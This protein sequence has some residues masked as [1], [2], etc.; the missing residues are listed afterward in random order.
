[1]R[2]LSILESEE[3]STDLPVIFNF[4]FSMV[5]QFIHYLLSIEK[6]RECE[7]TVS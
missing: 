5:A 2:D 1:M 6:V 4:E 3:A 7:P